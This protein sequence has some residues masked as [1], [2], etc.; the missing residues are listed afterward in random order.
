MWSSCNIMGQWSDQKLLTSGTRGQI[1]VNKSMLTS[2]TRA[3]IRVIQYW[4]LWQESSD[5]RV[6]KSILTSGTREQ[7]SEWSDGR[8]RSLSCW[9][10]LFFCW[11]VVLDARTLFTHQTSTALVSRSAKGGCSSDLLKENPGRRIQAGVWI[12]PKRIQAGK[13][14]LVFRL[15][16]IES[17]QEIVTEVCI[18]KPS[19][20][21]PF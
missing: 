21:P 10:P 8:S 2:G 16:Q 11:D 13:S 12:N 20:D 15:T 5:Q 4:P 18:F 9:S 14:R 6:I 17:R 1:R 19:R 3:Q 7:W